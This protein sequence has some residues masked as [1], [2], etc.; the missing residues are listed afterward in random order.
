MVGD[1]VPIAGAT[2]AGATGA[3]TGAGATGAGVGGT[4]PITGVVAGAVYV[5]IPMT[6]LH[7]TD[8]FYLHEGDTRSRPKCWG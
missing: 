6:L 4:V 5:L 1:A 2:G 3:A 8:K 7:G